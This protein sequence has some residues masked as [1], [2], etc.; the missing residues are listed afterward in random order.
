MYESLL[1]TASGTASASSCELEE[2]DI[3][4]ERIRHTNW[5]VFGK[6]LL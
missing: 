6:N 4:I 1:G 5:Y 3:N 2:E